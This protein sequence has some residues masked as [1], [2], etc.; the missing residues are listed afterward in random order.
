LVSKY[1]KVSV[2]GKTGLPAE[3]HL[4]EG[5]RIE[6][7]VLIK[8]KSPTCR[9]QAERATASEREHNKEAG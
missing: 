7:Q 4:A 8:E 3:A 2:I 6:V 5:L 9:L 1:G